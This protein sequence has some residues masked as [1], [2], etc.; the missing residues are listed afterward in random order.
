MPNGAYRGRGD[1]RRGRGRSDAS[2]GRGFRGGRG[3]RA[4]PG[5]QYG[6][7]QEALPNMTA[8]NRRI[9]DFSSDPSR[10]QRM[11][12]EGLSQG[13]G[14]GMPYARGNPRGGG[15]YR[16]RGGRSNSAQ[17]VQVAKPSGEETKPGKTRSLYKS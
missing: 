3:G 9:E 8:A 17:K 6:P 13:P 10:P 5:L 16:G 2:L 4:P 7:A 12:S 1:P 15:S 11:V 14:R